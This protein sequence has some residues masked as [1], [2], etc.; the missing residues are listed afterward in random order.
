MKFSDGAWLMQP[1]VQAHYPAEAHTVARD[2]DSLVIHAPVRP[3]R[4]RGDTL[5]GPLLTIRLSSPMENVIR[6][7]IEH[8]SG[9]HQRG[10]F[11]PLIETNPAVKI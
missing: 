10:P 3:I 11:L 7:R 6:V 9:G 2:G 5:Q 4:H 8:F 1:G